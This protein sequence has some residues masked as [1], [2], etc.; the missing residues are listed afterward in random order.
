MVAPQPCLC[1][2]SCIE[3]LLYCGIRVLGQPLFLKLTKCLIRHHIHN[4]HAIYSY[5][6]K[7]SVQNTFLQHILR[8]HLL[9]RK[10]EGN[11]YIFSSSIRYIFL[12]FPS[13][14]RFD[15]F[16]SFCFSSSRGDFSISTPF[17]RQC[18]S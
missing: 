12:E 10:E 15:S 7:R 2:G 5:N 18:S 11:A 16:S 4:C 8:T 1:E 14:L 3:S 13:L 6:K 9:R 17:N